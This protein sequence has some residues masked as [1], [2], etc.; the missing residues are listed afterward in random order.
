MRVSLFAISFDFFLSL[1]STMFLKSIHVAGNIWFL[2]LVI[3]IRP[4]SQGNVSR[5]SNEER[6][7]LNV[8]SYLK[9]SLKK[10]SL[11]VSYTYRMNFR[12]SHPP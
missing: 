12:R 11:T 6:S 1:H 9:F 7:H 2:F 8:A 3:F 10:Y 4:W 5:D